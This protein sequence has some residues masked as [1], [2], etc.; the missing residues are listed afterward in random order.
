[1]CRCAGN[2]VKYGRKSFYY[3]VLWIIF[4]KDSLNKETTALRFAGQEET[5]NFTEATS[6]PFPVGY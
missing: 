5:P 3:N 2:Y 4:G 1:M 6:R